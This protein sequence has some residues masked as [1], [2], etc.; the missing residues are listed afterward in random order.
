MLMKLSDEEIQTGIEIARNARNS[1]FAYKS[2]FMVGACIITTDNRYFGGCNVES[3]I[4]GLGV[5]AERNAIDHAIINGKYE[6]KGIVIVNDSVESA[7]PC[8]ACLQYVELFSQI[9][10]GEFEIIVA[11]VNGECERHS[12]QELLP[13]GYKTQ[14]G[15]D[16]IR[17]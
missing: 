8:G 9:T 2:G 17:S 6:Y 14:K 13:H 15:L 7:F 1:A 10:D 11:N 12:L 4:S 5:C 16:S 3:A